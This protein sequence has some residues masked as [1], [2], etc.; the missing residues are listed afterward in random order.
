MS[1]G[2]DRR[3]GKR[4]R[5]VRCTD[6]YS[7]NRPGLEGTVTFVDDTGTVFVRWD[8]GSTLGLVPGEDRWEELP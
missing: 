4:V 8:N 1:R 3:V 2:E 5:L 6:P 7:D